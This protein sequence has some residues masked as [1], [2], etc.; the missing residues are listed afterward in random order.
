MFLLD[1]VFSVMSKC[2]FLSSL[3][4]QLKDVQCLQV[5]KFLAFRISENWQFMWHLYSLLEI[6]YVTW[7]QACGTDIFTQWIE[8]R[9]LG[10]RYFGKMCQSIEY[11]T[12]PQI[13]STRKPW[14]GASSPNPTIGVLLV[15]ILTHKNGEG[16]RSTML[17]INVVFWGLS[18]FRKRIA[19]KKSFVSLSCYIFVPEE[20][21][22]KLVF[23][24][25]CTSS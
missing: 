12:G 21:R 10:D 17:L 15:Q 23:S 5:A 2:T 11:F 7:L 18:N 16:R 6:T 19:R 4:Q 24:I 3:L 9:E 20:V 8:E 22:P 1:E 13:Q 14:I 25:R